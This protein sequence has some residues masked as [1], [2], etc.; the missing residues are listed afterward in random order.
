MVQNIPNPIA[1]ESIQADMENF[2]LGNYLSELT[3]MNETLKASSWAAPYVGIFYQGGQKSGIW[4]IL[5]GK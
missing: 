2:E 5:S 4:P 3:D 1:L